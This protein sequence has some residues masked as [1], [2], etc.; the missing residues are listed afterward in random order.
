MKEWLVTWRDNAWHNGV[1]E[2]P[3]LRD[4]LDQLKDCCI[5]PTKIEEITKSK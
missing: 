2:A 5:R 4:L 3:N 1:W